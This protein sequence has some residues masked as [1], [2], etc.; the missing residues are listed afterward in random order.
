MCA[1]IARADGNT[2]FAW[3]VA[4]LGIAGEGRISEVGSRGLKWEWHLTAGKTWPVEGEPGAKQPHGGLTFFLDLKAAARRGCTADPVLKTDKTGFT[5]ELLPGK[6]MEV[7][8]SVPLASLYFEQ[9]HKSE[10][11]CMFYEAP[12]AVGRLDQTMTIALP[13]GGSVVPPPEGAMQPTPGIGSPPPLIH[14]PP[15]ST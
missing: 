6:T 8:F 14:T 3:N 12:I 5:W 15:S 4:G 9:G 7:S 10:I 1:G 11:R 13:E 2:P